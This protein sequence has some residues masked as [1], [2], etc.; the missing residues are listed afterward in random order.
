M[1]ALIFDSGTL[2]NLSMNGLLD[3]IEKLKKVFDGKFIITQEV[4]YEIIDRPLG[5]H[6]FEL[7]ALMVKNMLDSGVLEL[8][9]ALGINDVIIK[10]ET[11]KLMDIAN[12][13][14]QVN[15]KWIPLVSE[16][17]TSC[18]AL[19]SELSKNGINNLIAIDERTTR[20]LCE[21]PENLERLMSERLHEKVTLKAGNFSPFSVYKFIR[22]TELVFVAYKKG[23]TE[24]KGKQA[25]EA[26][27]YATKFKG[28]AVSFEEIE[29]MKK[30]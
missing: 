3:L 28:C 1:K 10:K 5:I 4:K 23:L 25:L 13:S 24:L 11:K 16:A 30:L 14:L 8:P 2:I 27:L 7:G 18:L 20:V 17:E 21:N 22:S 19:S 15:G 6:R 29:E 26:L 9:S 12:R